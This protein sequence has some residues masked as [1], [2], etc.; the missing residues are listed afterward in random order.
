[1][2]VKYPNVRVQL[3]GQDGNAF[4]IIGRCV[5]AAK[6]QG[7][8]EEECDK[9]VAEATSG[10]YNRLLATAINWFSVS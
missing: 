6:R 2:A 7:V 3:T 8:S 10:D 4:A 9:F 5:A 1:M